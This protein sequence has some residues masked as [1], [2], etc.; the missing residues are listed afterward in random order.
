MET[1]L[2]SARRCQLASVTARYRASGS[3]D[4]RQ[5]QQRR[6]PGPDVPQ[7]SGAPLGGARRCHLDPVTPPHRESRS[8]DQ[9]QPQQRRAPGPAPYPAHRARHLAVRVDATWI[10]RHL[11]TARADRTT[12]VNRSND[13]LQGAAPYPALGRATWRCASMPLGSCDISQ[14]R[15]PIERPASTAATTGTKARRPTQPSCAP[16]GGARR[17]QLDSATSPSLADD[18]PAPTRR[19][20]VRVFSLTWKATAATTSTRARRPTQPSYAPLGGARRCQLDSVTS[21][22]LASR[23][24]TD[25]NRSNHELPAHRPTQPKRR[26]TWRYAS[27]PIDP[28][29]IS[30]H[31]AASARPR[32]PTLRG[33]SA[34]AGRRRRGFPS[35]SRSRPGGVAAWFRRCRPSRRSRPGTRGRRRRCA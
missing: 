21:P 18:L 26:A 7:P 20:A 10:L 6:A 34:P 35:A 13:E 3:N 32:R 5:P 4:Q 30:A 12:S 8:N 25:A 17:C 16:L 24:T 11:P 31:P 28:C 15:K 14:P 9:R 23:S 33:R 1:P 22:S 27:M 2:G 29:D 19:L